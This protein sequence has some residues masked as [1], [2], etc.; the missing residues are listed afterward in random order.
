M[1]MRHID[2]GV[3]STVS[4]STAALKLDN[5]CLR[6]AVGESVLCATVPLD[7]TPLLL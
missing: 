2:F 6:C 7:G 1:R 5:D 3:E 4:E